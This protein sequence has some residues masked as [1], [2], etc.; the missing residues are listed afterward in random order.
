MQVLLWF[1]LLGPVLLLTILVHELGH[2]FAAL[3][4]VRPL[5]ATGWMLFQPRVGRLSQ[6]GSVHG[7][8]LWPLGGLAFIGHNAGEA[9]SLT[10]ESR[11]STPHTIF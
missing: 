6:G 3:S 9:V 8:L 2:C 1:L 5:L 4:V 10:R 11:G 7:I